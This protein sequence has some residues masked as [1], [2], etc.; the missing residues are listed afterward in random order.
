MNYTFK[1]KRMKNIVIKILKKYKLQFAIVW[2][3]IAINMYLLT[4][5]PQIIGKIIDLLYNLDANKDLIIRQTIY[6]ILAA[7][8][9]LLARMPWR[10]TV[11]MITRGFE[12]N[13]KNKLFDHFMKIKMVNLQNTKN[14]ELM[15]YFTK[16]I[17]EIRVFL[18]R[19]IALRFKNCSHSYN[20]NLPNDDRCKCKI[21]INYYVSYCRNSVSYRDYKKICRNKF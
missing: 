19:A 2:I 9:L 16:D 3:F 7:I 6:L 12:K 13:L 14:G 1:E 18:Y 20:R 10:Y 4:I 21:N 5:P 8:G 17:G 15:S 11:G